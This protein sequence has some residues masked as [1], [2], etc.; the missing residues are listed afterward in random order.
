MELTA[1]LINA[2]VKTV[3]PTDVISL[4]VKNHP[5]IVGAALMVL[6]NGKE[7]YSQVQSVVN[8]SGKTAGIKLYRDLSGA[9]PTEAKDWVEHHFPLEIAAYSREYERDMGYDRY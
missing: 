6:I 7:Y 9:S 2:L 5:E 1:M 4:I 8:T 3:N